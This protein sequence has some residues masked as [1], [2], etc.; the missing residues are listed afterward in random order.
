MNTEAGIK[1]SHYFSMS[2]SQLRIIT[3]RLKLTEVLINSL[4][5][6]LS[7]HFMQG[8]VPLT[9]PSQNS[10]FGDIPVDY[11]HSNLENVLSQVQ[12]ERV[13]TAAFQCSSWKFFLD[14]RKS[15]LPFQIEH[16][17]RTKLIQS[18][19]NYL[20]ERQQKR[21]HNIKSVSK[22]CDYD[23]ITEHQIVIFCTT[24]QLKKIYS[25]VLWR[26]SLLQW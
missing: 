16:I 3:N 4:L 26:L 9:F 18:L 21:L 17:I 19:W 22:I 11:S 6:Q 7:P 5:L 25:M 15:N 24:S 8:E 1:E 23:V 12:M 14:L 20:P 10:N 13:I 2:L